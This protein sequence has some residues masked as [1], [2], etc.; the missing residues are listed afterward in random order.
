[1]LWYIHRIKADV[2]EYPT[3]II[4]F[5]EGSISSLVC[6]LDVI[7]S[8]LSGAMLPTPNQKQIVLHYYPIN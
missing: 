8:I 7:S 5:S 1:M 2:S 6:V 3:F 4:F